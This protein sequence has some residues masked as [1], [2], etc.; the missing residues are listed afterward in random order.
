MAESNPPLLVNHEPHK[1]D[2]A[3][4]PYQEA[5]CVLV[6]GGFQHKGDDGVYFENEPSYICATCKHWYWAV[7]PFRR[8]DRNEEEP[9]GWTQK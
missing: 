9:K 5:V 4:C 2:A 3:S 1:F 8:E 6:S 7:V